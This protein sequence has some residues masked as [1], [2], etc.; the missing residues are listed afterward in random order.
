MKQQ[1][2]TVS[3][4]K[5]VRLIAVLILIVLL[6]A[7]CRLRTVEPSSEPSPTVLSTHT[8]GSTP[9]PLATVTLAPS[10][11][12]GPPQWHP[13]SQGIPG[14]I[15]VAAA[16]IAPS[17]PQVLYLAAYEP[18]GLYRSDDGGQTWQP[19]GTGLES[20]APIVLT[21]H[22]AVPNLAWVGTV[23]GAY[24]TQDGGESWHPMADLSGMPVYALAA[25]PD[26]DRLYAGGEAPSVW[27]SDDSGQSWSSSELA[28]SPDGVLSLAVGSDGIVYAG[29]AGQGVWA[30]QDAGQTWQP[31]GGAITSAHV[32]ILRLLHDGRLYALADGQSYLFQ[33][34][35]E[36]WQLVGPSNFEALSFAVGPGRPGRLYLGSKGRGLAV[37]LD[38]GVSWSPTGE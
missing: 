6:A 25:S 31:V 9:L 18:G 1:G 14:Q 11:P 27:R 29:T 13:A 20:L 10:P 22:P 16:A 17:D 32:T 38:G 2:A 26:G 23:T 19:A 15:G 37:S 30:S 24:R 34:G 7:G 21:V 28:K 33:R 8:P 3:L 5:Y 12:P 36:S 35:G 4:T